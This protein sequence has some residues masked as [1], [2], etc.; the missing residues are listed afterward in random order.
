LALLALIAILVGLPA[1]SL[2]SEGSPAS[3]SR[4]E[5]TIVRVQPLIVAG[6]AFKAGEK[7]SLSADG[8]RKTVTAGPRGGFK[9]SFPEMSACN[10]VTVVARGSKGSRASVNFAQFSNVHCLEPDTNPAA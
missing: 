9:V 1:V 7:V 4:A 5:L 8:R 10:G 2:A 3:P 6:R